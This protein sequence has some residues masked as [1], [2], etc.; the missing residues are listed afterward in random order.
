MNQANIVAIVPVYNRATTVLS[1]LESIAGQSLPPARLIVVDDG[2]QDGS[3]DS[4]AEWLATRRPPLETLVIRKLNGGVSSARNRAIAAATGCE[5]FAFL[6]S[7]DVWPCD[8]LERAAAALAQR[9]GA[10]AATADR[11]Y[12]EA[13]TGTQRRFDMQALAASPALWMLRLG[14]AICSCSVV[15]AD[16]VCQLGGFPQHLP[17]GEDAAL[18][19]PLS[20]HGPWLH[21]PGEPVRFVRRSPQLGGEEASLSRK[22]T[23]NQ[24]RW[25]R[26]YDAFFRGLSQR[27]R[28]QVGGREVIRKM[29][30]ERWRRAGLEL[31]RH[32]RMLAA[33]SCYA[34]SVRWR[35]TKWERWQPL[36]QMPWRVV[37]GSNRRAA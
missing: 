31:E 10:V 3:A 33:A 28:Q 26:V 7:D 19:L 34:R 1:T 37:T 14:A 6:D 18:F 12:V 15:R 21:L 8:F 2:S 16:L 11:L 32:G 22:F 4:V 27:Q 23:D 17:T 30:S 35:P 13:V 9:P 24:R 20:L 36:V 25:A 29:M 5:W